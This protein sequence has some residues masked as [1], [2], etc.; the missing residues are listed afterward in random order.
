MELF[1]LFFLLTCL[2]MIRLFDKSF[3]D[4][5]R[6][7]DK[8]YDANYILMGRMDANAIKINVKTLKLTYSKVTF[9]EWF[10]YVQ[11]LIV[12]RYL[13]HL[14]IYDTITLMHIKK[15]LNTFLKTTNKYMYVFV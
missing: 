14:H 4:T 9:N 12:N 8:S 2:M 5:A 13:L 3:G 6:R 11:Y 1:E 15:F 7:F 10:I